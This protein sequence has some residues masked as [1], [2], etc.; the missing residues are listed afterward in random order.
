MV[1]QP[2]PERF[3]G[4]KH[5]TLEE[6]PRCFYVGRGLLRRASDLKNRNHKHKAIVER[7][8]V[9]IEV[10][11]GPVS[12]D[13][14]NEWEVKTIAGEKTF[15]TN[16]SHDDPNDI[17]CNFTLGGSGGYG[18][19]LGKVG[20]VNPAKRAEVR[21]KI[22]KT[23]LG[24]PPHSAATSP[25]PE[26]WRAK[27]AKSLTGLKQSEATKIKRR[28]TL[29]GKSQRCSL[30]HETGHKRYRC[31]RLPPSEQHPPVKDVTSANFGCDLLAND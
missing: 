22:S 16:H 19:T 6:T 14:S 29:R 18:C 17:G 27:I 15:S 20:D 4:Y 11:V 8:G 5:W 1:V 31:P 23:L 30:C 21:A 25:K 24:H 3:Y 28:Q 7:Y 2:T 12:F 9:R 13:A 26:A 10:C